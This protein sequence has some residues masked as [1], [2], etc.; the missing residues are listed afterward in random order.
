M[1]VIAHML[2]RKSPASKL[3]VLKA[4]A[5]SRK[6][7][8]EWANGFESRFWSRV[9]KGHREECWPWSMSINKRGYGQFTHQRQVR[10]AHR[11]AYELAYGPIPKGHRICVCHKCDNKPCCNPYHLF[12]GTDGD[13]VRDCLAKG[14]L[15][16]TRGE[17]SKHAKLNNHKVVEIRNR[18]ERGGVSCKTLASEYGVF[19]TTIQGVVSFK[20]WKHV[21]S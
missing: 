15:N 16:P 8:A 2:K 9:K 21:K 10:L 11:T 13:N 12:L 18:Y 14:R 19:K 5:A 1:C 4:H 17:A 3:N 7:W 6:K 20:T